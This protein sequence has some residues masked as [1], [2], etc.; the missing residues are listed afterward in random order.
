MK[1][2]IGLNEIMNCIVRNDNK[3]GKI[4]GVRV[5]KVFDS[6]KDPGN[7]KFHIKPDRSEDVKTYL[8]WERKEIGLAGD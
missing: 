3:K 8:K 1:L 6:L 7:S 2:R 5:M 4:G